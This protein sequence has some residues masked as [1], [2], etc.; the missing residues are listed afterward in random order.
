MSVQSRKRGLS[1]AVIAS[2]EWYARLGALCVG[3]FTTATTI[4]LADEL[5]DRLD[6]D[7]I[8]ILRYPRAASPQLLYGR[9]DHRHRANTVEDYLRGHYAL[10]PFYLRCEYCSQRGLVSLRDVIEE[11]FA[12]SEYYKVHYQSAGLI[13]EMCFCC[14]DRE[15][16]H[17]NLSLSRT[18]G[19]RHFSAAELAGARAIAPLVTAALSATWRALSPGAGAPAQPA[20][21]DGDHHRH[22]E[23]VRLNFGRSILT[24]REYEILQHLL[25]GN[26]VDL[27]AQRLEIAVSTVKVHRKHIYSKLDVNSQAEIFTLFLEVVAGTQYEPGSDPLVRYQRSTAR[28]HLRA[29]ATE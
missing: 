3:S 7:S 12:S 17:L 26:S 28:P 13:D 4:G 11:D 25:R 19:K 29:D 1:R 27:I 21:A 15:G 2:P 10:D 6:V 8:L 16:G 14:A 23:N 5:V 20:Q 22:I 24:G 9:P 18:I